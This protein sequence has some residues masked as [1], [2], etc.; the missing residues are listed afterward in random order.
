MGFDEESKGYRIYWEDKH[1]VSIEHDVYFEKRTYSASETLL[2]EGETDIPTNQCSNAT[3]RK[4][5]EKNSSRLDN[6]ATTHNA[7]NSPR[8]NTK[9]ALNCARNEENPS[10]TDRDMGTSRSPTLG[11]RSRP[12]SR[13]L[14]PEPIQPSDGDEGNP[15]PSL[16]QGK[17]ARKPPGFYRELAMG[18]VTRGDSAAVA[19][20][21][22]EY[23]IGGDTLDEEDLLFIGAMEMDTSSSTG[24][25][26]RKMHEAAHRDQGKV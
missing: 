18:K 25:E 12:T 13:P 14:T 6:N 24:N 20:N 1:T 21:G 2:I 5:S 7:F 23:M 16:G 3:P 8:D 11:T 15:E 17:C 10:R 9:N 22:D 26:P 4:P 19:E